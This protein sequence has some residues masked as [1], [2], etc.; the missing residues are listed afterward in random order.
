MIRKLVFLFIA[1]PVAVVLIMLSVANRAPVQVSL[2][3][4]NA[5][6]PAIA[7]TLPLFACLFAALLLGMVIGSI[8]TWFTQGKHRKK[9]RKE[10][11]EAMK[12]Q[13]EA[14]AQ[15][16]RAEELTRELHPELKSLPASERAA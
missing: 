11:S 10:H 2:D 7:F 1:L 3:P 15:K 13:S 8:A 12:W 16:K 9:L 5:T 14:E 6:D 4:F